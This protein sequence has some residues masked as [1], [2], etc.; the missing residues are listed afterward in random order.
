MFLKTNDLTMQDISITIIGQNID[1]IDIS[2]RI[3][4]FCRDI[5]SLIM[6][7]K[8]KHQFWLNEE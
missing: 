6:L 1:L 5:N 8:K 4:F 7:T 3:S 2:G